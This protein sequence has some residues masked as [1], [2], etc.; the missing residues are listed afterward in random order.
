M[1]HD[2][3]LLMR[4]S[5][6]GTLFLVLVILW[7]SWSIIVN[8][9]NRNKPNVKCACEHCKDEDDDEFDEDAFDVDEFDEDDDFKFGQ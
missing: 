9:I 1:S 3:F 2:L 8:L 7:I 5:P 6:N 4:E